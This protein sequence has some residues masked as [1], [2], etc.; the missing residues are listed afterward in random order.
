MTTTIRVILMMVILTSNSN[1]W[2]CFTHAFGVRYQPQFRTGIS[3]RDTILMLVLPQQL[4]SREENG[5]RPH[6]RMMHRHQGHRSSRPVCIM[7]SSSSNHDDDARLSND[8]I[9]RYSRHLVLS[10]VGM[11]GQW[12]LK[13]A[14]VLV[15]GAGGLGSPCLLYLAAAGVG[16][17]GIVDADTVDESNLQRQ[18]IH[19]GD[20]VGQTK[21][22]SA[23]QR[24]W[25]LN[26]HVQV[27]LFV[28]EFTAQSAERI[29]TGG[30]A[31][32]EPWDL[33]IDGSDN[34]P[35]KYLIK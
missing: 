26:P 32:D 24:L 28:E 17:I 14:R 16:G 2:H 8:E 12:A 34:F 1:S 22:D 20:T 19:G 25:N 27:R 31:P 13:Q 11:T 15:I 35:T 33:V 23:R 21:C 30:F 10:D 3:S 29:V 18:I 5:V 4:P 6:H 9:R 7:A